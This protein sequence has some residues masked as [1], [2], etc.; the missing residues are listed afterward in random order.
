MHKLYF[1]PID[2]LC[3]LT[4][5]TISNYGDT[6]EQIYNAITEMC[7]V[8]VT[9]VNTDTIVASLYDIIT[10]ARTICQLSVP[11]TVELSM[12]SDRRCMTEVFGDFTLEEYEDDI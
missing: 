7:D 9:I 4:S 6:T 1:T 12:W 5:Y 10:L 8:D 3:K 2:N 11:S